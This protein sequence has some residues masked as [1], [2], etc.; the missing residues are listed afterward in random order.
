M[1]CKCFC[2]GQALTIVALLSREERRK[3]NGH[4][5]AQHSHPQIIAHVQVALAQVIK[6]RL[7]HVQVALAQVIKRWHRTLQLGVALWHGCAWNS[8]GFAGT[9]SVKGTGSELKYI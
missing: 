4:T 3:D 8:V 7:A 1:H 6:S 9:A 2:A 5:H